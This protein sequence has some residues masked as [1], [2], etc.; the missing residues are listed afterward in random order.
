MLEEHA[1]DLIAG[2]AGVAVCLGADFAKIH[3]PDIKSGSNNQ[4]SYAAAIDAAV[5]AAGRQ[6]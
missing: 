4:T 3:A 2:A 6:N 1:P 5:Q